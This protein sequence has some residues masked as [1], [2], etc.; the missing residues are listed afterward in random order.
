M[1]PFRRVL[2]Y[3]LYVV[4]CALYEMQPIPFFDSPTQN[5]NVLY[6]DFLTQRTIFHFVGC[7]S[8][9]SV[10]QGAFRRGPLRNAPYEIALYEMHSTKLRSTKCTL[11]NAISQGAFRRGPLRNAPYEVALYEMR[12]TKLRSTK[13]SLRNAF[14]RVHFVGWSKKGIDNKFFTLYVVLA[15]VL[16]VIFVNSLR[17]YPLRRICRPLR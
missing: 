11:R 3:T 14:R 15:F 12:S 7:M 6:V 5:K 2:L 8:Q 17:N 13:C 10:S 16:Y 9:R 1:C 4:F